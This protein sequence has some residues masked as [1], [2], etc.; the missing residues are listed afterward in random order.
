MGRFILGTWL[1]NS[2][3]HLGRRPSSNLGQNFGQIFS[4]ALDLTI[5]LELQVEEVAPRLEMTREANRETPY[6]SL[7]LSPP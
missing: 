7:S 5:F 1:Q 3:K 6:L 2:K 4:R